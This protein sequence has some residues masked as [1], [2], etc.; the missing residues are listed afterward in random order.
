MVKNNQVNELED[1]IAELERENDRLKSLNKLLI[2]EIEEAKKYSGIVFK[3]NQQLKEDLYWIYK[4]RSYKL[5]NK[6]TKLVKR[7]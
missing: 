6:L 2:V 5:A 7:K 1:R 4:S 3:D